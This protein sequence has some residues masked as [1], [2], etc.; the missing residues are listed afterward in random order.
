MQDRIDEALESWERLLAS[1]RPSAADVDALARRHAITRGKWLL[2]PRPGEVDAAWRA[3]AEAA[4]AGA[5]CPS[6]KISSAAAGG[7]GHVLA[8]YTDDYLDSG[9]VWAACRRLQQ[10]LPLLGD[11]RML[12]KPDVYTHLGIY[13]PNDLGLKPTVFRSTLGR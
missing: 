3:V 11:A 2:F 6:A 1:R 8:V 5:L 7:G 4:A 9:A 10:L 13:S 12:Y